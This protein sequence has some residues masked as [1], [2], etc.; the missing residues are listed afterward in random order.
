MWYFLK[1]V[2]NRGVLNYTIFVVL[3]CCQFFEL[4]SKN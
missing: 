4:G 1:A 3:V 2:E